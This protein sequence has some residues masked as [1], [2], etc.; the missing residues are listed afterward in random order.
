[1]RNTNS[2]PSKGINKAKNPEGDKFM[3]ALVNP[4]KL[5][6]EALR[7]ITLNAGSK[8]SEDITWSAPNFYYK[9]YTATF[10]PRSKKYVTLI[11][12]KGALIED[13]TGLL[14]DDSQWARTAGFCNLEYVKAKKAAIGALVRNWIKAMDKRDPE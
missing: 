7:E 4:L 6:I 1:M 3:R 14:E 11:F 8:I 9:E 5:E 12:H 13:T 2:R 10:N